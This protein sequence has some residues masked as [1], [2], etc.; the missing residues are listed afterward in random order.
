[1]TTWLL[2]D[3]DGVINVDTSNRLAKRAGLRSTHVHGPDGYRFKI[4]YDP[5]I[6]AWLAQA[7]AAGL[8]P[9][10]CST[11]QDLANELLANQLGLE[12]LPVIAFDKW[13][14]GSKVPGILRFLSGDRS[15]DAFVWLDDEIT[16]DDRELLHDAA[17]GLY[18]LIDTEPATGWTQDIVDQAIA[19][20][21][22]QVS[23]SSKHMT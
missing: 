15:G 22:A 12:P 7:R 17:A 6:H 19:F 16:D 1:M 21:K 11:W 2:I 9:V 3:I 5:K 23:R 13:N 20:A 8:T 4:H 10:W 18:E 14:E